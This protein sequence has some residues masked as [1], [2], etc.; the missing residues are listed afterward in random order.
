MCNVVLTNILKRRKYYQNKRVP[1]LAFCNHP[2]LLTREPFILQGRY[3]KGTGQEYLK[4]FMIEY[5]GPG[6]Y[7]QWRLYADKD[8][9]QVRN[10]RRFPNKSYI[11][12]ALVLNRPTPTMEYEYQIF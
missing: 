5:K 6:I 4:H 7:S 9:H 11:Y 10:V 1:L 2:V 3:G 12:I 8:S